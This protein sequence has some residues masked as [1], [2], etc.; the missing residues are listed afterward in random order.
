MENYLLQQFAYFATR[1][2]ER[3]P[4]L[5]NADEDRAVR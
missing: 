3:S 5:G 1:K 2:D 4:I